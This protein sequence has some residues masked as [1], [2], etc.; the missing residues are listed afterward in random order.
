MSSLL[1]L[2]L[3]FS[4]FTALCAAMHRH[5]R[6]LWPRRV[7]SRGVIAL[8]IGGVALLAESLFLS[9]TGAP[10]TTGVVAWLGFL[11]AAGLAL[12]FLLPYSPRLVA[13]VAIVLPAL[14]LAGV[15]LGF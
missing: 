8:R 6:T 15:T 1:A 3:A 12:V 7:S 11:T 13:G 10:G 5:R 2:A 9:V 14:A 4:G